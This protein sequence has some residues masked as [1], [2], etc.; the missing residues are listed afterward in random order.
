VKT[1][2]GIA[3]G[4]GIGTAT[5][6]RFAKEG[7]RVVL[8]SRDAAKLDARAEHLKA[9][10]YAVEIKAV[11]AG[12]LARDCRRHP[13]SGSAIWRHRVSTQLQ[14]TLPPSKVSRPIPS[15]KI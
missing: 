9:K 11:D 15:C 8:A 1:F 2:L 5:A 3:S 12:D 14:C 4:P 10:G 7:F 6:N 13:R